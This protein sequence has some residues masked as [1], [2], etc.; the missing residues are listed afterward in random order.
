[1]LEELGLF[2]AEED[3]SDPY[4]VL[5]YG[6]NAYFQILA[7]LAKMFFWCFL[8][9]IPML[10]IYGSGSYYIGQKS[11]P[12]SR[13]FIGNF[14]GS[15]MMCKSQRIATGRIDLEC[16]KGTVFEGAEKA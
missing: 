1:M 10:Y 15:N 9:S 12:I 11:F 4:L 3:L 16:P 13:F 8:F 6:V 14:G 2:A 5:G 7:S